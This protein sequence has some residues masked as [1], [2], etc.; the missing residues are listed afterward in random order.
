MAP[1]LD[2]PIRLEVIRLRKAGYSL[3][4]ISS[5]LSI[6]YQSVQT[7]CSRYSLNEESGL[8]PRY[9]SCGRPGPKQTDLC[10][11]AARWLKYLHPKWGAPF[12]RAL[13]V[14][15]YPDHRIASIRTLQRWFR[16]AGLNEPR[17]A[18]PP[19]VGRPPKASFV[20]QTWEIDA[21]E[22][23]VLSSG[24]SACYLS[25]VDQYSGSLLS[26]HVFPL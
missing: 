24:E 25:I 23:L 4:K 14:L 2:Y 7:L 12:I 13:L 3:R 10:F 17:L 26:A 8:A 22:R 20:H 11:R 5:T 1:P 16:Q 9:S 21:K 19:S 18:R 15:R 6:S